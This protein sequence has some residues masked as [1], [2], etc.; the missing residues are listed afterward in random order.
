MIWSG[1]EAFDAEVGADDFQMRAAKGRAVV[2][3]DL[4]GLPGV[5]KTR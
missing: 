2:S 1:V 3:V 4:V 5:G